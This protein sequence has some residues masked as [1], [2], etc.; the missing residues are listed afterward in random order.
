MKRV[1]F[2]GVIV[3]SAMILLLNDWPA[4]ANATGT[5][6]LPWMAKCLVDLSF[7]GLGLFKLFGDQIHFDDEEVGVH[8]DDVSVPDVWL[9]GIFGLNLLCNFGWHGYEFAMQTGFASTYNSFW[10][11]AEFF[12]MALT[13]ILYKHA[14]QVAR[15]EARKAMQSRSSSEAIDL[16]AQKQSA[17]TV[18]F[19][20]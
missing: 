17:S 20:R 10:F 13:F 14:A 3:Y 8:P 2:F 9:Y 1:F 4:A 15:R 18:D 19:R 12:A 7:A 6:A 11:F 16:M 5:A